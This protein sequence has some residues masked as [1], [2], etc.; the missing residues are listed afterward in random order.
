MINQKFE[1]K[2]TEKG[3]YAVF[4]NGYAEPLRNKEF[5]TFSKAEEF[6]ESYVVEQGIKIDDIDNELFKNIDIKIPKTICMA[7]FPTIEIEEQTLTL[8]AAKPGNGKTLFLVDFMRECLSQ[9]MKCIFFSLEMTKEGI[10]KRY[11]SNDTIKKSDFLILKDR[12]DLTIESL[13]T[14]IKY[15]CEHSSFGYPDIVFVDY[16]QYFSTENES[17]KEFALHLKR[18]AKKYHIRFICAAQLNADFSIKK[19]NDVVDS[20]SGSREI[21]KT[22][23]NIIVT[24]KKDNI[25]HLEVAK[26]RNGKNGSE[27]HMC[28][29]LNPSTGILERYIDEDDFMAA[30][31]NLNRREIIAH[32]IGH[33]FLQFIITKKISPIR[34]TD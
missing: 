11:R 12:E 16:I 2:L 30:N 21:S 19:P 27:T 34:L 26:C 32:E 6:K 5:E 17:I 20:M 7:K 10:M 14:T 33:N 4:I 3:T 9:K 13:E 29:I 15:Y 31:N 22:S 28:F 24:Y 8:F 18:L 1:I 25:F 23:E